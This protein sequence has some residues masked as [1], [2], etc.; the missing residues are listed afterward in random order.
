MT[1]NPACRQALACARQGWPVFPCKPGTKHP[2]TRHGFHDATTDPAQITTW[3]H[4]HPD[5]NLAI[6]TGHP[7]PD[8]LDI[9]QHGPAG[10]GYPACHRLTTAGLLTG[11]STIV[12]TPSGGLHL[13]FTGTTQPSARLP[14]HHLDFRAAGGYVL[15][16]PSQ[17]GGK[18][19]RLVRRQ[20]QSASLT[21]TSV[22]TLLDPE[23][24]LQPVADRGS[25][26]RP[27]SRVGR[28]TRTGQPQ[29]RPVLGCLPR[30]RNWP[31]Q[32]ARQARSR[33]SKDRPPGLGNL[34]HHR[35]GAAVG[36]ATTAARLA[37]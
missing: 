35:L 13:Y 7:G 15:A 20:P 23:P 37:S 31:P 16:P 33:S 32:P 1:E 5:A 29:Q 3:W 4:R 17:I 10:N 21:W 36:T 28:A 14:R 26:S 9:D 2:A 25:R 8:V 24:Q 18:H 11:A 12:A 27:A 6:A 34:P 22:T 30:H 19:H